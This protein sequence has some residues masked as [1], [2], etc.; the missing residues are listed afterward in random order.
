MNTSATKHAIERARA[1]IGIDLSP[2]QWRAIIVNARAGHYVELESKASCPDGA[3]R[4][5]Y[6]PMG[7]SETD[8]VVVPMVINV[9]SGIVVT[10][11]DPEPL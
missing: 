3:T 7:T 9:D 4:A 2:E 10:V 1:R 5:Y 8:A 6:V 11:L